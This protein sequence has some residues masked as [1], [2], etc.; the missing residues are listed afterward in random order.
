MNPNF[1]KT[2]DAL[3]EMNRTVEV[4]RYGRRLFASVKRVS[5]NTANDFMLNTPFF[6]ATEVKENFYR[7]KFKN[8][9]EVLGEFRP[10]ISELLIMVYT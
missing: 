9:K 7:G 8:G 4:Y 2:I 10:E 5:K 1:A 3:F 6:N